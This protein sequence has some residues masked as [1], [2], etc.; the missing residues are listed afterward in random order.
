MTLR[1]WAKER[2]EDS[3]EARLWRTREASSGARS[4]RMDVDEEQQ[5]RA[6]EDDMGV[7]AGADAKVGAAC[8]WPCDG[9]QD[10]II[11]AAR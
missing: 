8:S 1:T 2:S 3:D 11:I 9:V 7:D 4:A 5:A 10:A 6:D